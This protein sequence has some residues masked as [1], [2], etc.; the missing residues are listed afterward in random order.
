MILQVLWLVLIVYNGANG[1]EVSIMQ[2]LC[3]KAGFPR[4]LRH[5]RHFSFTPGIENRY[6]TFTLHVD[7][8]D[9]TRK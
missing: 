1:E 9:R 6:I 7:M 2:M 5:T 8:K 3:H 4:F